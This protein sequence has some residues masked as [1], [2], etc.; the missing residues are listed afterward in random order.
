VDGLWI[1]DALYFG[2]ADDEFAHMHET[3]TVDRAC[4]AVTIVTI[5]DMEV[6][7]WQ[8][9]EIALNSLKRHG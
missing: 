2:A 8:N 9:S 1:D 3:A 7:D 6:F 5:S 4:R